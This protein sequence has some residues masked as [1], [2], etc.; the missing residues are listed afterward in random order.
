MLK[1]FL[2]LF[3]LASTGIYAQTIVPTF[4]GNA[5]HTAVYNPAA[6]HLNAIHWSTS[7]DL[8]RGSHSI[9]VVYGGGSS[10]TGST[11]PV[12]TQQVN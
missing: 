9:T 10:F 6:Q 5:Q 3:L 11:S 1:R 12:L 4:G 2:P 8:S 7:I